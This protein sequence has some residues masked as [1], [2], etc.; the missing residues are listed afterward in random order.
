[1]TCVEHHLELNHQ[2]FGFWTYDYS[3]CMDSVSLWQTCLPLLHWL[4]LVIPKCWDA[5]HK[6]CFIMSSWHNHSKAVYR[7]TCE[8]IFHLCNYYTCLCFVTSCFQSLRDIYFVYTRFIYIILSNY[9]SPVDRILYDLTVDSFSFLSRG[10][11][12][13]PQQKLRIYIY[14]CTHIWVVSSIPKPQKPTLPAV[15]SGRCAERYRDKG[16]LLG[17]SDDV[18]PGQEEDG[19]HEMRKVFSRRF[20]YLLQSEPILP[21][22]NNLGFPSFLVFSA[23]TFRKLL[24]SQSCQGFDCWILW[25]IGGADFQ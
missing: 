9:Y 22:A 4:L 12:W 13:I 15:G 7:N 20:A 23:K 1:M 8:A 21:N 2:V 25:K 5:L 10:G 16:A 3:D 18:I 24:K 19:N 17:W 6:M 14:T 11:A